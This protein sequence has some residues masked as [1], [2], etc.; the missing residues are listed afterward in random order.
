MDS[1]QDV[2]GSV[3]AEQILA[4]MCYGLW[5]PTANIPEMVLFPPTT[6]RRRLSAPLTECFCLQAPTRG[7]CM[8]FSLNNQHADVRPGWTTS[9]DY[10][11]H[12]LPLYE[13][14]PPSSIRA[15]PSAYSA[16]R[17]GVPNLDRRQNS[18]CYRHRLAPHRCINARWPPFIHHR[19]R[20]HYCGIVS[21][22][23]WC[24]CTYF[25]DS[26]A[27]CA[28][29]FGPGAV[30]ALRKCVKTQRRSL[31]CGCSTSPACGVP[32]ITLLSR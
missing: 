25:Q 18:T 12:V 23:K 10:H 21:G 5:D 20:S 26:Q 22:R 3:M 15:G 7:G 30:S 17:I 24:S 19:G 29:T 9:V 4:S 16:T 14:L 8:S 28:A 32:A 6:T 11:Q 27:R 1:L 31:D 2:S 13:F